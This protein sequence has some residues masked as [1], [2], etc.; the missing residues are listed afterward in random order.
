MQDSVVLCQRFGV[1][2]SMMWLSVKVSHALF[3]DAVDWQSHS[4]PTEDVE[5][6]A[7]EPTIEAFNRYWQPGRKR[8]GDNT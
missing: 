3:L 5:Q 4:N 2:Y 1:L 6:D 8:D 7:F